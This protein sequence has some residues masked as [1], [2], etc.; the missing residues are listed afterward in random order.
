[1]VRIG[2]RESITPA[3]NGPKRGLCPLQRPA[4]RFVIFG[5]VVSRRQQKGRGLTSHRGGGNAGMLRRWA[6]GEPAVRPLEVVG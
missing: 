6:H 1:M 4:R 3:E 2:Q 5:L